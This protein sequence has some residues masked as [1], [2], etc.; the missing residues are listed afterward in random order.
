MATQ[1]PAFDVPLAKPVGPPNG[2][3]KEV[4]A[5]S[6]ATVE[7][8]K[9]PLASATS[10]NNSFATYRNRQTS[11]LDV[12]LQEADGDGKTDLDSVI[13]DLSHRNSDET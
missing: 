4:D 11:G 9:G 5:Q 2:D 1:E 3:N 7:A 6:P 13:D 10:Q 12:L 8:S